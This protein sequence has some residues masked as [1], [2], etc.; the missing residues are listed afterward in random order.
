MNKLYILFQGFGQTIND[1]N[2]K[3][4]N[5]LSKL[6]QKGKVFIYQNKW[7]EQPKQSLGSTIQEVHST[8]WIDQQNDY[9]LSYLT[10]DGFIKDVYVNLMKKIP[11][12][13]SFTWIP[14]GESFGGC[15]ALT[16]SIFF[17]KQCSCCVL[18]DNA[19]YFTLKSNKYRIKMTEA[20]MGN[21]FKNLT[22]IQFQKIKQTNPDYLLDYGVISF[23]KYIQKNIIGKPFPVK[24]L[25]FYDIAF[26]DIYEKEWKMNYNTWK[27][28][29]IDELQKLN[30]FHYYLFVNAGHMIYL[31]KN[32]VISI[33]EKI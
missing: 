26:P 13:H 18:L 3:P 8:S 2:K 9:P 17:N 33:L 30:N 25:G 22:E 6:K 28:G 32:A 27:L 23:A 29:E 20:M 19:P 15:F 10:M 14:I 31:D 12:A 4:T 7:I 21:K 24:I 16:F 5:F 11:N 1:W